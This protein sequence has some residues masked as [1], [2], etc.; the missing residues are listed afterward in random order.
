[1]I[2]LISNTNNH[3]IP[4]FD[5]WGW[6]TPRPHKCLYLSWF[7]GKPQ[8]SASERAKS[9]EHLGAHHSTLPCFALV[10]KS[11]KVYNSLLAPY[12]HWSWARQF[13][14]TLALLLPMFEW[15][16]NC[17]RLLGLLV[18]QEITFQNGLFSVQGSK[19]F[20]KVFEF[21]IFIF[22]TSQ[23]MKAGNTIR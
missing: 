20:C 1:M 16:H 4:E 18:N 7:V 9:A 17:C 19:H 6:Y 10:F 8:G 11:S 15:F 13:I 23:S 14:F 2:L 21:E 12:L 5:F 3:V 22:K